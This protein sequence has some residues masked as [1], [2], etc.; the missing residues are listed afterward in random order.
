MK[1]KWEKPFLC[2]IDVVCTLDGGGSDT[3][4]REHYDQI[5]AQN[6]DQLQWEYWKGFS[7]DFCANGVVPMS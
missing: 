2:E 5:K 6:P 3:T 4:E 1:C 7:G